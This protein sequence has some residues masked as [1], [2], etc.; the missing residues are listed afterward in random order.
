[1]IKWF[2]CNWSEFL[3]P[4]MI[5]THIH[6]SQYVNAGCAL[7]LPLLDWLHKYTFP[8]EARFEDIQ[9]AEHVYTRAVV[10]M[11]ERWLLNR[12]AQFFRAGQHAIERNDNG[13]V[14]RDDSQESFA[15]VGRYRTPLRSEGVHR[16]NKYGYELARVLHGEHQQRHH[17][18]RRFYFHVDIETG[19]FFYSYSFDSIILF[20][21][22]LWYSTHWC[23]LS[24]HRGSQ[25]LARRTWWRN[26][27]IWL[28]N[29]I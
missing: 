6:A 11:N 2:H 12:N 3:M 28:A 21:F 7:D 15:A 10:T 25:C 14:F 22:F 9:F 17:R 4:G 18:C 29:T 13:H 23:N 24:S 26:W 16:E 8:T 5:D 1:M 27:V 19:V 20:H